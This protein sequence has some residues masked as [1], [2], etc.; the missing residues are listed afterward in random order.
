MFFV[1]MPRLLLNA[2]GIILAVGILLCG[3][4]TEDAKLQ[5][6]GRVVDSN[7]ASI[8]GARIAAAPKGGGSEVSAITDEHGDFSFALKP[9][10]YILRVSADNFSVNSRAI[11]VGQHQPEF[12]EI[13]L[14]V[15]EMKSIV[16]VS[17]AAR[18]K[19]D[20]LTSATKTLTPLKDVPQSIS[21]LTKEQIGDQMLQSVGDAVRYVPGV[22]AHQGEN[23]RDQVIIRGQNTSADFFL[24]GIRDDVQYYR[25][26]YNLER[27]EILKGPNA[28]IFGRGGGGGVINRVTKEAEFTPLREISMQ[29]GSFYD[30]RFAAD[31]DRPSSDTFAFRSNGFYEKSRSFRRFAGLER[32]GF[33]P[34]FTIAPDGRT[35]ITFGYEFFRDRRVADRGITSFQNKPANVPISTYYGNPL[36]SRVRADVNILTGTIERQ[37]GSFSVRDRAQYG[38]YDRFYQNY[39]PGAAN[40]AGTSVS[41]SAYNNATERNNFFN[42]TDITYA[43]STGRIRHTFLSG[44]ELGSQRTNNFRNTGYFNDTAT[45][46][47]ASFENPVVYT[48]VT[49]RQSA[50]DADNRLRLNLGAAY[51]QDQIEINRY[52]RIVTGLRYDYFDLKYHD[53][54]SGSDLRRIDNLVSPRVGLV[55][56]PFERISI[57]GSYSVSYLPGSGDQF[58]SL[59]N[60]TQQVKPEKFQN[61]E[62]GVKWDVRRNLTFTSALFRLNR[63]NTRAID[64]NNPAAIIQTGSQRSNGFEAGVAG[65]ITPKWSVSGGYAY[66]N[67][68][69]SSATTA[70]LAGKQVGQAPHNTFSL[71]NKYQVTSRFGAG[72]G[73][74][75][76]SNMFA[77]VD[78]TVTLPGYTRVDAAVY[79]LFNERWRIQVNAE[80]LSNRKYYVNADS[81]TNISPGSPRAVRIGLVARF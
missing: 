66:Q 3:A 68:F 73:I 37:F 13:V 14:Q 59:T 74:I 64:P 80:N 75:N 77:A 25:D 72:L 15:A 38:R 29:G 32:Y 58:S 65:K 52:V 23:N 30:R 17:D 27:L 46:I 41:I 24:N 50:T 18:Y 34:T 33:N 61:Y 44:V 48:P 36:N 35:K 70:A 2:V 69:I 67:A 12:L 49:F 20:T 56:K 54:R 42:Q 81:N 78:N 53:N 55:I 43:A 71:W 60:V 45:S 40:A 39:V 79:Y 11:E 1:R 9:G 26:F 16:N 5:M 8:A 63:T 76:R 51:F 31:I 28:M 47:Q 57:Y 22:A 7:Q 62:V 19:V 6:R 4:Q 10:E 21:V